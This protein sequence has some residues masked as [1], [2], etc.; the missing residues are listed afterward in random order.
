MFVSVVHVLIS[1]LTYNNWCTNLLRT[2]AHQCA[3][4]YSTIVRDSKKF[5]Q[6]TTTCAEI[7][8]ATRETV[9]NTLWRQS[10]G[11]IKWCPTCLIDSCLAVRMAVCS[12]ATRIQIWLVTRVELD[13]SACRRHSISITAV[14]PTPDI[15]RWLPGKSSCPSL[16]QVCRTLGSCNVWVPQHCTNLAK[17]MYVCAAAVFEVSGIWGHCKTVRNYCF[18]CTYWRGTLKSYWIY[19]VNA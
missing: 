14:R 2:V 10:D 4:Y 5:F 6:L 16:S 3:S 17:Y 8:T 18:L 12:R 19:A 11:S 7:I 9:M 15:R 13:Q 1:N